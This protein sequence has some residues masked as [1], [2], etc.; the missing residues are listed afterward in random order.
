LLNPNF[1]IEKDFAHNVIGVDEVGRGPLAGPV[2]SCA[3]IFFDISMNN[4]ELFFINDSKKLSL[5]K[6][7]E[8]IREI[9]KLKKLDKIKYNLGMASVEEIDKF[10]ILEATKLSMRRAV[11]KLNLPPTQL[12]IDGNIDLQLKDYPSESVIKG[13][14]KSYSIAAASIIAKIHRDQYMHFLSYNHPS[15]GW[16][17]NA[18]YGTKKHIEEIYRNGVTTHHRKSFEPIKSLI[19]S[20]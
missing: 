12:I 2:I 15:Y 17:S 19:H 1:N 10:N 5:K 18:G 11:K 7:I 4:E 8:A 16:S 6:R 3:F 13:D 14:Q 9:S 20:K